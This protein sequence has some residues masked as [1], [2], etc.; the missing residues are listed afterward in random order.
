MNFGSGPVLVHHSNYPSTTT[1]TST[2]AFFAPCSA[3]PAQSAGCGGNDVM[4][5]DTRNSIGGS[6]SYTHH[7]KRSRDD[8]FA[9][10]ESASFPIAVPTKRF[11]CRSQQRSQS[12]FADR[13]YTPYLP[14]Y[15]NWSDGIL[16][17][18]GVCSPSHAMDI[19]MA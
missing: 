7:S 15:N 6:F 3:Y 9:F 14:H 19:Y 11:R 1:S 8:P 13:D 4:L 18:P 2:T 17:L 12:F 10:T 16:E 5:H